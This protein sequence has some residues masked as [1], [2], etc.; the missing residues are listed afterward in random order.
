VRDKKLLALV[1]ALLVC[2][3]S[4]SYGAIYPFEIFTTNGSYY[5]DP[6]VDVYMEVDNGGS[7]V[8]FTF[9]ND[10]TVQSVITAIYFDDGTLIGA[11]Q[12]I[13]NGTGTSFVEDGPDNLPGGNLIGFDADRE[14][15]VN[16]EPPAPNNGVNHI[17]EDEWVTIQFELLGGGTLQD[18]LD[19]LDSGDLRVGIHIQDFPD[20]PGSSESAVN[21]PEPATMVLLGLGGLVLR[22]KR[23]I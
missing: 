7:V 18:V 22:R 17:G 2:F 1:I 19:E 8:D 20:V 13:I 3:G 10:S 4:S 6:G 15:N 9:Y 23:R 12:A 21:I 11:T 14:F 16:A 5:D